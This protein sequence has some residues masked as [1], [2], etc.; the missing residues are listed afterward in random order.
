MVTIL[1]ESLM[2]LLNCLRHKTLLF[3]ATMP[4]TI[5]QLI[6]NYLNKNVVQVSANMETVGNQ[7][8]I[9]SIVVDPIEKL[10]VLMHFLNSKEGERGIY[11]ARLKRR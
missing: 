3:S 2:K 6:Q 5:K 10:D 11:F 8:S 4:G 7:E 9:T 1:K